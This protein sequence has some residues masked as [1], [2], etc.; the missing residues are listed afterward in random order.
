M[1]C[2]V[3]QPSHLG[4]HFRVSRLLLL[5]TVYCVIMGTTLEVEVEVVNASM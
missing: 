2:K 5:L 4:C 3:F 1:G